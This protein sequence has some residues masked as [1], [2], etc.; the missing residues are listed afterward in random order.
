[1]KKN[2]KV[3]DI[4]DRVFVSFDPKTSVRDAVDILGK[5]RLFGACVVDESGEVLGILSERKCIKLYKKA[6]SEGTVKPIEEATVL[7]IMYDE[8]RTIPKTTGLVEAAQIFIDTDFRRMPVVDSNKIIG[9]I[10]RR[11]IIRAIEL[12]SI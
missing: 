3:E 7:D 4:M 1:M 2:L 5:K 12:F 9:Q 6:L 11:D 10:T 8:F